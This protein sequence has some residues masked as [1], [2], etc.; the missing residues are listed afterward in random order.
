MAMESSHSGTEWVTAKPISEVTYSGQRIVNVVVTRAGVLCIAYQSSFEM[1]SPDGVRISELSH[2]SIVNMIC[3]DK[4]III[5]MFSGSIWI[6][7]SNNGRLMH[8]IE[9]AHE[10]MSLNTL[11]ISGDF[12]LSCG[13]YCDKPR[14]GR[15]SGTN[16]TNMQWRRM[17]T[18]EVVKSKKFPVECPL[19]LA[20][21]PS[22]LDVAIGSGGSNSNYNLIV[23]DS[24][25]G[26]LVAHLEGHRCSVSCL[27]WLNENLLASGSTDNDVRL[28]DVDS[29]TCVATLEGHTESVYSLVRRGPILASAS[30]DSTVRLWSL[31]SHQCLQVIAKHRSPSWCVLFSGSQLLSSC[32][33]GQLITWEGG[34]LRMSKESIMTLLL[35]RKHGNCPLSLVSID[36]VK[37]IV[38][39]VDRALMWEEG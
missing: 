10:A 38:E 39:M 5:A 4:W 19:A 22:G 17:G 7:S 1:W 9:R 12:L 14:F 35:C 18:W 31:R 25:S 27:L 24:E 11:F 3:N 16:C 15:P 29:E 8:M 6:L 36:I 26:D 30:G 21:P 13:L 33:G 20:A 37:I 32:R 34:Y 2:T 28:W 23:I